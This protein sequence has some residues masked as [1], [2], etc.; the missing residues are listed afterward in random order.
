LPETNSDRPNPRKCSAVYRR[1]SALA[2]LQILN[3]FAD[4]LFTFLVKKPKLTRWNWI[5][6]DYTVIV[7]SAH[8]CYLH[9]L[10]YFY[11]IFLSWDASSGV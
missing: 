10:V 8:F 3:Q 2:G 9:K 1:H 7:W 11:F 6:L 4:W 5:K